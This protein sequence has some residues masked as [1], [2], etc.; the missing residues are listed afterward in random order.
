[1]NNQTLPN[2]IVIGA[3][4]A[5]TSSLHAYL[6]QHP[7]IFMC[8][9]K[10]PMFFLMQESSKASSTDYRVAGDK[11][12]ASFTI[13]EYKK[14]F[15][16]GQNKKIRGES[17]T[18]YLAN[19]RC[20]KR[21]KEMVPDVKIIA[22]LREPVDRAFS[23]YKMYVQRGFE[24]MSFEQAIEEEIKTGRLDYPDGMRYLAL[25]KYSDS[26][27]EYQKYFDDN[28]MKVFLYDQ[29][30]KD[31]ISMVKEIFGF[32]KVDLN[33]QPSFEKEHNVSTIQR[34]APDSFIFKCISFFGK[35]F[36]KLRLKRMA[37]TIE[38]KKIKKLKLSQETNMR[39]KKYFNSEIIELEKLLGKDLTIW[40]N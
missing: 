5:G 22:V 32:L 16:K 30:R 28:Q 10:E 1:M 26:I 39:L 24:K 6:G 11:S 33:F 3:N 4:K 29:F 9:P 18:A 27:K 2:L 7:E 15:E 23:N 34:Y 36:R 12:G 31:P 25:S 35:V 14:L 8:Y 40:K 20:A 17:S 21:I 19:P 38:G 37:E 13:E